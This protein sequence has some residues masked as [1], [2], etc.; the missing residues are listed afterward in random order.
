[1][2]CTR[3]FVVAEAYPGEMYG[4]LGLALRAH[5]GK[6][7]QA[8]RLANAA[9]L[10][11][12]AEHSRIALAPE[13]HVEIASGFGSDPGSDDRFDAVVGLFGLLNVL[14]GGRPSGEPDDPVVRRIEG[15]ILGLDAARISNPGTQRSKAQPDGDN[16]RRS[17]L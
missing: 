8:A 1:L 3:R 9:R 13:L 5:G 11:G 2:L 16:A 10:L 17:V 6:R 12:W 7:R 4:H 15:W 14:R